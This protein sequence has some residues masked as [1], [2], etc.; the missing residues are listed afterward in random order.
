VHAFADH[1]ACD[2]DSNSEIVVPLIRGRMLI[3]V[4]DVDSPRIGRFDA[5]DRAGLEQLAA[6]YV[7]SLES[8]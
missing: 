7:E 6:L 3:G 4:L 2:P 1:I 5:Q 8:R